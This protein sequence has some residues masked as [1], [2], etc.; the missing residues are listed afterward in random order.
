[1]GG[2]ILSRVEGYVMMTVMSEKWEKLNLL[3][4]NGYEDVYSGT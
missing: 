3:R 4:I 1:M 2:F